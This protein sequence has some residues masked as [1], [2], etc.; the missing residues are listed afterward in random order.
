MTRPDT[1][2]PC[3]S[4]GAG[5]KTNRSVFTMKSAL[6]LAALVAT[7]GTAVAGFDLSYTQSVSGTGTDADGVHTVSLVIGDDGSVSLLLDGQPVGAP[8]LPALPEVPST[9]ELPSA[10]EV[11][12]APELPPLPALP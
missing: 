7:A 6:L 2:P 12:S 10:P 3:P 1:G 9:P 5:G 11:P 4:P 8:E